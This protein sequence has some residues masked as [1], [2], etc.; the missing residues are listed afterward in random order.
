MTWHYSSL[1]VQKR[2]LFHQENHVISRIRT[3]TIRSMKTVC[4]C[5]IV[6][7]IFCI[8]LWLLK[9]NIE[10]EHSRILHYTFKINC[11]ICM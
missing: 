1:Y 3:R 9:R 8:V 5:N 2:S 7:R 11:N 10:D 4:F 6:F